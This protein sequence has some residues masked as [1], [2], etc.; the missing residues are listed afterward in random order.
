MGLCLVIF[1]EGSSLGFA[2][3][4]PCE[5]GQAASLQLSPGSFLRRELA[6]AVHPY[7]V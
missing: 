4:R 3:D 5:P 1:T 7:A 2:A 6:L